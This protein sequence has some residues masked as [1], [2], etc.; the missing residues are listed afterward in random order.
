MVASFRGLNGSH[1]PRS[2]AARECGWT[3]KHLQ[4]KMEDQ[5]APPASMMAP[6]T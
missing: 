4:A 6:L 5:R 3:L 2:P 1:C